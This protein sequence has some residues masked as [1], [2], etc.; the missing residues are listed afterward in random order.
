MQGPGSHAR[1]SPSGPWTE[2]EAAI[3]G[4]APPAPCRGAEVAGEDV[5]VDIAASDGSPAKEV[6]N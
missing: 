3:V 2:A 4:S 1:R 6:A 5:L